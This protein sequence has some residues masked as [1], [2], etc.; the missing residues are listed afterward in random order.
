MLEVHYFA[1]ARD[2]AG[3][4][5][6]EVAPQDSLGALVDELLRTHPGS[7][8]AGTPMREVL[9]RCTFLLD[10]ARAESPSAPLGGVRRVDV[11]PPFAGG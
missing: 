11:L 7:T 5:R 9:R 3:V 6:E 4:A 10:G 8:E 2:A 1:A